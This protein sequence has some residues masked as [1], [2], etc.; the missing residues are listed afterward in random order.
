MSLIADSGELAA[1]C[2]SLSAQPFVCVDTEFI[3]DKTYFPRLCLVQLAGPDGEARAVDPL[4]PGLDMAPLLDLMGDGSVLKVLHAARQ[5]LEIFFHLSGR[6]PGPLFDSQVAAMVCGFGEAIAYERLARKIA[7]AVIDKSSRFTDWAARPLSDR[8]LAYALSDVA[9]LP[10]IYRALEA[11][12]AKTGRAAWLTEELETLADPET[13]RLLPERAWLRI[14]TR[15][16]KPRFLGVLREVAAARERFAQERDLPR[17]RV[18]RDESLLEI[19]AQETVDLA[20]LERIRGVTRGLAKGPVGKALTAAVERGLALPEDA[21]PQAVKP[22]P[23]RRGVGPAVELLKVLLKLRCEETEVA[24]RLVASASDLERLA[25]DR[26]ADIAA[27]RGWRRELFGKDALAL[28]RG[29]F[30]L[31]A[32]D[33]RLELVELEDPR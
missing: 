9:H 14:K 30:A 23:V 17:N 21:L 1:L 2:R 29:D 32:D 11:R 5:D 6:V 18:L 4:A 19:A 3:R 26:N 28:L 8:Q 15:S 31:T 25:S 27:T 33:G 7:G 12:L 24:P 22:P 20:E 13:Y 16:A 10:D